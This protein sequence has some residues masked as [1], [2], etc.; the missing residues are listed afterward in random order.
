MSEIKL[1]VLE[2]LRLRRIGARKGGWDHAGK[3]KVTTQK[4]ADKNMVE[5]VGRKVSKTGRL[6]IAG[7]VMI[8]QVG[9]TYLENH[10]A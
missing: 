1:G 7:R 8:T 10:P 6:T 9:R 3:M 5:I 4:L 2:T